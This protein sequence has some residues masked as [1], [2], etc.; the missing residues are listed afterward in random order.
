MSPDAGDGRAEGVAAGGPAHG[1]RNQRHGHP[2][3]L[4]KR[5]RRR[6]RR[7]VHDRVLAAAP[8]QVV[9]VPQPRQQR[10]A[11]GQHEHLPREQDDLVPADDGQQSAVPA[12]QPAQAHRV[13]EGRV[14]RVSVDGR[15]RELL[16]AAG[17]QTRHELGVL[18][19][20]L[21]RP[22]G[23]GEVAVRA[24]AAHRRQRGAQRLQAAAVRSRDAGVGRLEERHTRRQTRRDHVRVRQGARV[25]LRDRVLQ[26]SVHEGRAGLR[27]GEGAVQRRREGVQGR[28]D[29]VRLHGGPHLRER[30][31]RVG[32][33]AP[34]RRPLREAA[35]VLRVALD[36]RQRG[37]V[38]LG[39]RERQLH[40]GGARDRGAVAAEGRDG[41]APDRQ[42]HRQ[43]GEH[44]LGGRAVPGRRRRAAVGA[45]G[46]DGGR[47]GVHRDPAAE[48]QVV[49]AALAGAGRL[50]QGG[51]LQGAQL[52]QDGG[53]FGLRGRARSGVR[54][55]AAPAPHAAVGAAALAQ[56]PGEVAP[57]SADPREVLRDHPDM[58]R[59][60]RPAAAAADDPA[61]GAAKPPAEVHPQLRQALRRTMNICAL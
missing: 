20:G 22:L 28:A 55:S 43:R 34:P 54:G 29:H 15:D 45:G 52:V 24:G 19:R 57:D 44:A 35:A 13:H 5:A 16:D 37:D 6:V 30:Q 3:A 21:R 58:Q 2:G 39:R 60:V 17:G 50:R 4:R 14:V 33:A 8:V 51:P 61:A 46:A 41:G 40:R 38:R 9:A 59:G 56:F 1:A 11:Q 42:E 36:P 47:G 23:R 26:Q 31:E 48:V 12:V 53:Q 27:R 18:R 32:E 10:G 25:H 7:G 49:A